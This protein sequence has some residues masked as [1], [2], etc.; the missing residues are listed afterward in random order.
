MLYWGAT[1]G[2]G[3]GDPDTTRRC[4]WQSR[5]RWGG[6]ETFVTRYGKTDHSQKFLKSAFLVWID[7]EF[8]EECNDQK[9][10]LQI[11]S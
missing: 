8:H 11:V 6:E 5:G 2:G 4:W 9:T 7:A 1:G 10:K 3:A